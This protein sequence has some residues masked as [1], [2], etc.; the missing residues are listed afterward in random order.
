MLTATTVRVVGV[1]IVLLALLEGAY[2]FTG[3]SWFVLMLSKSTAHATGAA[4]S[5]I[6]EPIRVEGTSLYS[7]ILNMKIVSEC[8]SITPTMVFV[9]AVCAFPSAISMKLKGLVLGIV[10]LYIINLV[11]VVSLYLIGIHFPSQME[12]AHVV[13]W[14]AIMIL[15]AIG[16]WSL[17]AS[18]YSELRST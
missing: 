16:L 9:S 4:L 5:I 2:L 17:W 7:P 11:R 8:T 1:F 14:Q 6:G 12:F 18:K 13:V 15:V 3:D 10:A